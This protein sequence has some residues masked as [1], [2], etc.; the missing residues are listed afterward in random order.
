MNYRL[1]ATIRHNVKDTN[2]NPL[3]LAYLFALSVFIFSPTHAQQTTVT[4]TVWDGTTG[5][6][7]PYVKVQYKDSKI[8]TITDSLG[9]YQLATYYPSDS[10]VFS[11]NGY[12][13]FSAYIDKDKTQEINVKMITRL[14][15]IPEVVI[16]PPDELPST[17]LHKKVIAHKDANNKEKLNNYSYE[18]YNKIQLDLN[19]IGDKFTDRGLVKRLD[20]IMNYLDSTDTNGT[21]LPALLSETI[22]RFYYQNNPRKKH[23]KV[24]ATRVTGIDNLQFNQFLGEMYFDINVYDNNINFLN[25][26]FISPVS[27]T[28]RSFYRFYL[29]DSAFIDAQWC[30]KLRFVPKR[31]GDMTFEGEM[32]IND[33]T[34]AVKL[35]KA[36]ISPN[37]NINYVQNLYFEHHFDQVEKEVWMLTKEKL[38][39]DLKFTRKT[40]IYG[41]FGRKTATRKYFKINQVESSAAFDTDSKVEFSDSAKIRTEDYWRT[42]RHEPLGKQ[43]QGIEEMIDSLE[44][45]PFFNRLEKLTYMA[46]TGYYPIGKLEI[47]SATSL[48]SVNPVEK[49]RMALALRTSNDFSRRFEIGG[50]VAYGFGDERIKYGARLRYN[51]SPRKRGMLVGYYNYDIEQIG[52]SPTAA[53]VG[54]TFGTLL[55]TAPLDKLTFVQRAGINLEKDVKKDIILFGGFEWKEY[56]ALGEANYLRKNTLTNSYDTIQTIRTSE[57]TARFRWAKDEEFIGGSFDRS[58]V[59][60]RYPILSV[61]GIF[62]I[63]GLFGGNYN[64][65][66]IEFQMEHNRPIGFLGR[67]RYGVNAGYVFGVAGYPFLKVHEA[68]QSY[69]LMTNAFN[70]LNFFEFVSDRYVGGFI[71]NHWE[72]LFFDRIP[73]INKLKL[74]LVSS[75]RITYG[76]ISERHF[77]EMELPADT[78]QFGKTPYA[79]AS[80]GIENILKVIRID[81]VWRLTHLDPGMS[82]VGVRARWSFN[83]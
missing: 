44:N 80:I 70:K 36:T 34:Y 51:I 13:S 45:I 59:G 11:Y 23:E 79:E 56:T 30:Y 67:M 15:E 73:L 8:G 16:K 71:E 9:T 64:Y 76:A 17:R 81:V 19:N 2:R 33:T 47:G 42:H 72:G 62:G 20:V 21:Y 40:A 63:K 41:A 38:I 68:N 10:L 53:S 39:V 12:L 58:S 35:F 78:R 60:S 31:T 61:Q 75:A 83:L 69:W 32:W 82:P 26:S 5:H 74:R 77:A 52:L 43:E 48:V 14:S 57:I 24:E 46:T 65:Q 3:V 49:F 66:K 18:L 29:E 7:L 54:T 27:N 25:R 28:A 1:Q 50:R 55:N 22:S 4:G 37:A 6:P